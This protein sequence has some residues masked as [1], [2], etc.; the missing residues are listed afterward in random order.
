M[1]EQAIIGYHLDEVGD[2]VAQLACGHNQHVRHQ[3][4][5]IVRK[6]VTTTQGRAAMIGHLLVCK[7][8]QS[9]APKDEQPK[10][11]WHQ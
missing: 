11:N 2:W 7:K 9:L 4:P 6:W 5:W 10:F 3:P 8:C 1:K